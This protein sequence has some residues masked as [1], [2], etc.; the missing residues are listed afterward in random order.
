MDID[1]LTTRCFSRALEME[2]ELHRSSEW[3]VRL[4]I[5]AALTVLVPMIEEARHVADIDPLATIGT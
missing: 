1:D 2:P 3:A 5:L 4:G